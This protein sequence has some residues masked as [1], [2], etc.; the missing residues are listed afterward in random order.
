MAFLALLPLAFALDAATVAAMPVASAP[1]RLDQLIAARDLDDAALRRL[2]EARPEVAWQLLDPRMSAGLEWLLSLP[3]ADLRKI[4]TGQMVVYASDT[5][6]PFEALCAAQGLSARKITSVSVRTRDA[7]LVRIELATKKETLHVD[8]A[9]PAEMARADA[10]AAVEAWLGHPLARPSRAPLAD[11]SFEDPESLGLTW[12]ASTPKGTRVGRDT[13]R[14]V[15][16]KACVRLEAESPSRDGVVLSQRLAVR[17]GDALSLSLRAAPE[18]LDG[19][20]SAEFVFLDVGGTAL[21]APEPA[22]VD[23]AAIGWEALALAGTVP[24]ETTEAWVLLGLWGKGAVHFDDLRLSVGGE[25][26]ADVASWGRYPHGV[27]VVRAD[28]TR[29]PSPE[30]AA[31]RVDRVLITAATRL[32]VTLGGEVEVWLA[33]KGDATPHADLPARGTCWQFVDEAVPAG[34]A[35]SAV[36]W[37]A[38]GP[39]GNR[40]VA[41][42]LAEALGTADVD[43]HARARPHLAAAGPLDRVTWSGT[44]A[45][46]AVAASFVLWLLETQGAPAVR[47]A[48]G[49]RTL[50]GYAVAGQDLAALERAWRAQ[51]GR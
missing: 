15:D 27:V 49:A 43:I 32:G 23:P 35:V 10:V 5:G 50:E 17:P 26:P 21:Y 34:C 24:A 22:R 29:V 16:G 48:W 4:R 14:A 20:A 6:A 18:G 40:F 12:V 33:P 9:F 51:V 13:A 41:E 28:P 44:S 30:D 7:Q 37:R 42:G 36:A 8:L 47:A 38:W 1:A 11:P 2:A 39:P 46:R 25:P 31:A 45:Q 19:P 3:T